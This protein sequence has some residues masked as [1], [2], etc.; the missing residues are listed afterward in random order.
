MVSDEIT[1]GVLAVRDKAVINQRWDSLA[2]LLN[3]KNPNYSFKIKAFYFDE[4]ERA[5]SNRSVAYVL[6]NPS[7]YMYLQERYGLSSPI[8]TMVNK[9]GEQFIKSFGGVIFTKADNA[10]ITNLESLQ[11][12]KVAIVSSF[13]LGGYQMQAFALESQLEGL[14]DSLELVELG[15][16]HDQVV[17]KVLSGDVDAGF[18][19]TGVLEQMVTEGD[20]LL[21]QV[22][23]VNQQSLMSF[24]LLSST[25]LYPEWPFAAL[26]YTDN[27]VT[28]YVVAEL[29]KLT[30]DDAY[31]VAMNIGGFDI[32]ANYS[33][34]THLLRTQRF[35]PFDHD[36][37]ISLLD[38]WEQYKLSI[39]LAIALLFS[40]IMGYL[41][42]LRSNQ[43]L[44]D[45][46]NELAIERSMLEEMIWATH[47]G[48]WTWNFETEQVQFND[49]WADLLGYTLAELMPVTFDT[50]RSLVHPDDLPLVETALQ[51]HL[52][53]VTAYYQH[54]LRMKH[55]S[56]KW[57]WVLTQGKV[58][59]RDK[60]G[61]P[62][63]V[64]GIHLD[65]NSR[66]NLEAEKDAH[67]QQ[68]EILATKDSLTHLYNR[69]SFV[70][71][72]EALFEQ[73]KK[74]NQSLSFLMIDA[75]YFK[76]INDQYGHH[77][78][79]QV[80]KSMA[81]FLERNIRQGDLLAR[82]GG[83]EF[84]I[85]MPKTERNTALMIANR[86]SELAKFEVVDIEAEKLHFSLS[87][88]VAELDDDIQTLSQLMAE[89]DRALYEVKAS[90]RGFAKALTK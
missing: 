32:P 20:L 90:G 45:I 58:V 52:D 51:N 71:F 43:K 84:G 25:T 14:H 36:L 49:R 35:P 76:R 13:S 4:L 57:V 28:K 59:E 46:Q 61:T 60:A 66:K 9:T 80:L 3:S 88:G 87:I 37:P 10:S 39:V 75:D 2:N 85:L 6:A 24:P 30:P 19:R 15:M 44:A 78:G 47:V 23:I 31:S 69:R 64:S 73:A 63:R 50:W 29:L 21:E 72:G 89:A 82:L 81:A 65:I 56:G 67:R 53:G 40:L 7:F 16:P 5:V 18:V 42:L 41:F 83:E 48:T 27:E 22:K 77:A 17:K 33:S 11:N 38:V 86:I 1:I 74:S 79:D 34:I 26:P 54:E 12:K 68:L 62:L 70:E 8:L 55:K